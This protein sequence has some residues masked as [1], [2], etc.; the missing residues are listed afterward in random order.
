M[1]ARLIVLLCICAVVAAA[2]DRP[3]HVDPHSS[4]FVLAGERIR[5]D[6]AF[7]PQFSDNQIRNSAEATRAGLAR[8]AA[9]DHGQKLIALL[10]WKEFVVTITED[11]SEGGAGR[12]PQPGI[13][14]LLAAKDHSKVK[15]YE[16]ILNPAFQIP[17]APPLVPSRQPA[18]LVDM[19]AVAFA[20]EMLH[21]YFYSIGISLPHH[22]RA[23]FQQEWRIMASE[24]GFPNMPHDDD[25]QRWRRNDAGYR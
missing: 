11:S 21:I 4:V 18:T 5:F 8:W 17:T 23:D 6:A 20:G 2:E 15:T 14:T 12:A 9:T 10:D 13:A 22:Q 1:R 24:L 7:R 3:L 19:M 25:E 16:L